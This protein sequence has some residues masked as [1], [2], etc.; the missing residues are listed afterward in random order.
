M[1]LRTT[2]LATLT[3]AMI[4]AAPLAAGEPPIRPGYWESTNRVL[5]PIRSVSTETRC[6]TPADIEKF[7]TGPSNRRYACA[8][9]V[10]VITDGKMRLQGTC[11]GKSGQEI[12]VSGVGT[13]AP[14]SFTLT[15]DI[16]LEFAG[17]PIAGQASTD[18]RRIADDC[19]APTA[20]GDPPK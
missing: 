3:L 2:G 8:Y 1:N 11:V 6:I 5:S 13:Y 17:L 12:A 14:D 4:A 10:K 7:M 9:P 16:A 15:A 20:P 18:A 19:P